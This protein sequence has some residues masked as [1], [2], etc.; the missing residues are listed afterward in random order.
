VTFPYIHVLYPSLIHP[1]HYSNSIPLLFFIVVWVGVH[2]GIYKGP[3]NASNISYLNSTS[4]PLYPAA[5]DSWDS[6]NRYHFCI[7][8]HVY[9]LFAPYSS[10]YPLPPP[11]S[12]WCQALH[13]TPRRTCFALLFSDFVEEKR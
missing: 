5:P 1:L 4:P 11:C 7:H 12:H 10:S 6:F 8:I 13:H 9:T 3:Y 2:C